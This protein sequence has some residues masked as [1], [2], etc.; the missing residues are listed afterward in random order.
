MKV[1]VAGSTGAVGHSLVPQLVRSGHSVVG[2]TRSPAKGDTLRAAGAEPVIV[3]VLDAEAVMRAVR[4]A[5]PDAIVHQATAL[6]GMG[7]NL[8]RFDEDFAA[9]NRL[10]TQ[11]TDNLLAAARA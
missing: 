7:S 11:G 1:F 2:T 8:R 6:T 3:D 4:D 5:K 10:R 9:T